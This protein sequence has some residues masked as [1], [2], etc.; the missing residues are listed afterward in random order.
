MGRV[1]FRL[2]LITTLAVAGGGLAGCA[3]FQN[4][5]LSPQDTLA[6]FEARRL[7][8]TETHEAV[9]GSLRPAIAMWPPPRWNIATLT[10]V[11]LHYSTD[12]A[13][14]EARA[15]AAAAEVTVASEYPN[16]QLTLTPGF[17]TNHPASASPWIFGYALSFPVPTAGRRSAGIHQA[18]AL[19]SA[20]EFDVATA[21]WQARSNLRKRLLALYVAEQRAALLTQQVDA[22]KRAAQLLQARLDAGEVAK[23]DVLLAVS[24]YDSTQQRLANAEVDVATARVALAAA[25]GLPEEA[26]KD[27]T[28]AFDDFMLPLPAT[29]EVD[30]RRTALLNRADIRA[31]LA[32]YEG[33]QQTLKIE[34]AKQYPS[35]EIGPGFTWDQ[36][37]EKWSLGFGL[38]L[39]LFNHNQGA[40]AAAEARRREAAAQFKSVQNQVIAEVGLAVAAYRGAAARLSL[41]TQAAASAAQAAD[42]STAAFKAGEIDALT[43][44]DAQGTAIVS[45]LARLDA[46]SLTQA[47]LGQLEDALQQPI[48]DSNPA[49]RVSLAQDPP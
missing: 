44:L 34:I 32:R 36:G 15:Q 30:A 31:A 8:S 17:N 6:T 46:L 41:A 10:P 38:S 35:L 1:K 33:S 37:Q 7:D 5:P 47:T 11:A 26:L 24:A 39:P 43:L 21:A 25:L 49:P 13:A 19:G 40:V 2:A 18:Q 12:V 27:V 3:T 4:Q 22:Q 48:P 45:A 14:A 28:F 9:E 29:P 20:A 23:P 16:P 42:A